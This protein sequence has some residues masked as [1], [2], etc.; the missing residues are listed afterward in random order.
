[1]EKL[2]SQRKQYNFIVKSQIC[3]CWIFIEVN[4]RVLLLTTFTM[5][6]HT[7]NA[8]PRYV[9]LAGAG[10]P[11][12]A[13]GSSQ[14]PP[15]SEW[16][17]FFSQQQRG[18]SDCTRRIFLTFQAHLLLKAASKEGIFPGSSTFPI[19]SLRCGPL[20]DPPLLF[21]YFYRF[22]SLTVS[23]W[24]T[25]VSFADM[26]DYHAANNQASVGGPQTYMEQENDWDRDL[27]LD[28][29]WEKQQRKVSERTTGP[30]GPCL[31]G[32][33]SGDSGWKE[34]G[35]GGMGREGK[36]SCWT[37]YGP[38][39]CSVKPAASSVPVLKLSHL[40][41]RPHLAHLM[42]LDS[43]QTPF[44]LTPPSFSLE[45]VGMWDCFPLHV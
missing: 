4:C 17:L 40:P 25:Q 36:W 2:E 26:V 3:Q 35:S 39:F 27:L 41:F 1:M 8:R 6:G 32:L 31:A 45:D 43:D 12:G 42:L 28:P 37:E 14:Q 34:N 24:R 29:A 13:V 16:E 19:P 10:Q 7:G 5:K 30:A 33:C 9:Q 20:L 18:F 21:F 15:S 23:L 11:V 38:R 22:L 44:L